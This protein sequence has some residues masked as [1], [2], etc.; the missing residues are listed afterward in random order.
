[1]APP[2]CC[3]S[4]H[5]TSPIAR[6]PLSVAYHMPSAAHLAGDICA[7]ALILRRRLAAPPLRSAPPRH[8]SARLLLLLCAP[9][10]R[11][12]PPRHRSACSPPPPVHGAP[13]PLVFSSPLCAALLLFSSVRRS[14]FCFILPEIPKPNY[15]PNP[16][17]P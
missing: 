10:L 1:M 2:M 17:Q 13:A 6:M 11:S 9:L 5:A 16:V 4:L 15:N 14:S 7:A 3:R 12:A 8:R